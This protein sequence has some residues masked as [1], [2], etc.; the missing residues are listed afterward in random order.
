[1]IREEL[2]RDHVRLDE[3]LARVVDS[4]GRADLEAYDEFRAGLLRHIAIEEKILVPA[5][6]DRGRS[7]HGFARMRD[8]HA[9]IAAL[10]MKT[11]TREVVA[12]IRSVLEPHN[13]FEEGAGG[14]YET[15]EPELGSAA[16]ALLERMRAAPRVKLRPLPA[17]G[18]RATPRGPARS[19]RSMPG[20]PG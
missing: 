3:L 6:R 20:S 9:R 18:E 19:T 5:A 12:E 8:D 7:V 16:E 10:L 1:M 17:P 13:A 14:L 15:C 11:P 4:S 2:A